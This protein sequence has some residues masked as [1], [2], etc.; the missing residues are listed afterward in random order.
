[1]EI[2]LH[3]REPSQVQDLKGVLAHL[4][5]LY[6]GDTLEAVREF[7][8]RRIRRLYLGDEFCLN[9]LPAATELDGLLGMARDRN[10]PVSLLTPP[11]TDE[12][13]E[14]CT[15]LLD[16]L[17]T[18]Q[19]AAEVV[20]NDW[21]ALLFLRE[22][23]PDLDLSLG[24]LLNKGFKDPRLSDPGGFSRHSQE[25][26][27]LLSGCTFD[28]GDFQGHLSGLRVRR[29][30]RDLFP[31]GNP[32]VSGS[33]DFGMSVYFPFGYV[34]TGRVCW[35]ASIQR[36]E[37]KKFSLG[38]ACDRPCN[39]LSMKVSR[40]EDRLSLFQ[41]G[42]AVFY[43]YPQALLISFLRWAKRRKVRLVYQGLAI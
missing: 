11:L 43:L 22:K 37:K 8:P 34:T 26:A 10:W 14:R 15:P 20:A 41:G 32:R 28:S 17:R 16:R 33:E 18:A 5:T 29:L 4:T 40:P 1:M 24:R 7:L 12:G 36:P 2:A 30:E 27:E 31:Y 25:A 6:E 39:R 13:L 23:Y 35:I 3:L 9:R 42:N 21:G 19:P 38:T